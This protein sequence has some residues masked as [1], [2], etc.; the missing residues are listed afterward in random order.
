M[1]KSFFIDLEL[2]ESD[3]FL[4]VSSGS[5]AEQT[6]KIMV[7]LE[8]VLLTEEPDIVIIV[9]D[10]NTTLA[11]ALVASKIKYSN[12]GNNKRISFVIQRLRPLIVHVESGY[13][14]LIARC[15]RK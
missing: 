4:G 3:F 14:P 10:V 8:K 7:E 5:H 6:T 9:G 15:Q 11:C 12:L 2:P 1:S 13:V